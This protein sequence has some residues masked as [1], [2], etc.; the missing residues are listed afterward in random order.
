MDVAC[1][2]IQN[3]CTC[4]CKI[5]THNYILIFTES[6]DSIC[7]DGANIPI[8]LNKCNGLELLNADII[9]LYFQPALPTSASYALQ[10]SQ[11]MKIHSYSDTW[12]IVKLFIFLSSFFSSNGLLQ[13][14]HYNC[15]NSFTKN[16][17]VHD[18]WLTYLLWMPSTQG[19]NFRSVSV[20]HHF[21]VCS[22]AKHVNLVLSLFA[23]VLFSHNF[24]IFGYI[25]TLWYRGSLLCWS[26]AILSYWAWHS[27]QQQQC[28]D[29]SVTKTFISC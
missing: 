4:D 28:Q 11:T 20:R 27:K 5:Y 25:A 16:I 12:R 14:W 19:C 22:H 26:V 9:S 7:R 1:T 17:Y 2:H 23:A 3:I 15:S 24:A 13:N 8:S 6:V 18:P 29:V 10:Y 21:L